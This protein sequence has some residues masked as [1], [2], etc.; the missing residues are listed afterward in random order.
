RLLEVALLAGRHALV[1]QGVIALE[2]L[3]RGRAQLRLRAPPPRADLLDHL[4]EPRVERDQPLEPLGRRLARGEVD[5]VD[6]GVERLEVLVVH[7]PAREVE[8]VEDRRLLLPGLRRAA[9]LVL[10][11]LV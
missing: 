3:A 11:L 6:R 8:R 10:L 5:R 2:R 9:R 1:D 4:A 7:L